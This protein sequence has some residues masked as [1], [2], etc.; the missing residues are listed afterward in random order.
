VNAQKIT[1]A[2]LPQ[3]TGQ[4]VFD[5]VARHLLTQGRKSLSR[6]GECMYRGDRGMQCAAGCLIGDDEGP[7]NLEW[8]TWAELATDGR[9]PNEHVD[10]IRQL[11]LIHDTDD[12]R[13]WRLQL[14]E[15]AD[16]HGLNHAAID[17][18]TA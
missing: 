8:I 16:F 9:V 17:A 12:V 7:E 14:K 1:L 2:T 11:Q 4:A 6:D 3:A 10:L 15:C 13:D 18:V 5:Q